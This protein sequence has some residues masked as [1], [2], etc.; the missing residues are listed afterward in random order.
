MDYLIKTVNPTELVETLNTRLMASNQFEEM[1]QSIEDRGIDEP[2]QVWTNGDGKLEILR[3]HRRYNGALLVSKRNPTRFKELFSKGLPVIIRKD[4]T[5]AAE[6]ALAKV[7]HGTVV[8]LRFRSERDRA[9]SILKDQSLTEEDICSRLEGLFAKFQ[10]AVPSNKR[11]KLEEL[12]KNPI[13]N[14]KEI[15]KLIHETYKGQLQASIAVWK[16]PK[17]VSICLEHL[18]ANEPLP[19]GIKCPAKLTYGDVKKLSA[20]IEEDCKILDDK[21]MPK[22][23]KGNPGPNFTGLWAEML[24]AE[25]K[26]DEIRT[27]AM[28]SKDMQAQLTSGAW[29]SDG[30]KL[31]TMQH[32]GDKDVKGLKAADEMLR[33]CELVK[34][35]EPKAWAEFK[36]K[37]E[38]IKLAIIEGRLNS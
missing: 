25:T 11:D 23:S 16:C 19:K 9:V 35:H 4:V 24:K 6:A 14:A 34:K 22:H 18:E 20:A 2:I 27:K 5:N 12:R 32:S 28:S 3:G 8:T 30:F 33:L 29:D 31:L 37:G 13:G 15:R 10:T 17:I 26:K 36:A 21:G 38:G 1:A 7:D